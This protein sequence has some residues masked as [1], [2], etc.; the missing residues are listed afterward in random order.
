MSTASRLT[1]FSRRGAFK[2][3]LGA[4]AFAGIFKL[5]EPRMDAQGRPQGAP[6]TLNTNSAPSDLKITD[7]RALTIAANYDYPIIRIDT[8][9]GVY[10][11]GEV[12]DAGGKDNAL[13][14]KGLLLGRNP[15]QYQQILR[16]IRQFTAQ[17]RQAGGYS[18]IDIALHDIAGKVQGVPAWRLEAESKTRDRIRIYADTTSTTDPKIYATRMQKRKDMGITFFKM[19]LQTSL[20]RGKPGAIGPSGAATEKGLGYLC[21]FIAA[22]RDVVGDAP[23]AADHFGRLTVDEAI[24]Y[25]KAFEPYKLSWAEDLVSWRDWRGLKRIKENTETP[26]LTGEDIFG[27]QG[28]FDELIE[29]QAVDLIHTDPGTSGGISETK[30]IA[31]AAAKQGIHV[32]VHYAGS[33]VGQMAACHMIATI[34]DFVAMENHALDM[35]WWQDLVTGP[36]KP[37]IDKGYIKVPDTPGIGVELNEA[38]VK[39]HLRYPGYFAPTPE[40]DNIHLMGFHSGGPWPHYDEDDK[41]CNCVSYE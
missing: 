40:F 21:E 11:L 1:V 8:N 15:V 5:T 36:S 12:R 10:G 13:I 18:A 4:G 41:W 39:E 38:V 26:V 6:A 23:L 20:V 7:M 25:A 35:P 29:N 16:S 30:R 2:R 22:I 19:D 37:I 14:Y 3:V 27:L 34:P 17:G 28:G 31:E 33:P 9:Q 32:A 24:R